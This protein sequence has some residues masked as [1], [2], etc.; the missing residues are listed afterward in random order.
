L[1][2]ERGLDLGTIEGSGPGGAVLAADLDRAPAAPTKR[3]RFDPAA[4]RHAIG[5]AMARSKRE[6]PH[7]YLSRPIDLEAA[8]GW[9]EATNAAL[10]VAERMLPAVLLLKASALALKEHAAFNGHYID[11][12]FEPAAAVNVGWAIALRGGGLIAP[13]IK[14]ADTLSP[15]AL[16]TAMRDLVKRA[17]SGGLRSSELSATTV[18]ITSLGDRG[19]QTVWPVIHPPQVAMLGFGAI[20]VRP[21]VVD[22]RLAARR[23]V[24]VSLAA[25]H[26]VSDGHA[27]SALLA[28]IDALLATPETL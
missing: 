6:I 12:R 23:A 24:T 1:A 15:P 8:L 17:R 18:T 10:G 2:R 13:A 21:L 5:V 22:G 26:R 4:M 9:L 16:M 20:D 28:A 14:S 3:P 19:A 11:E 27:G 7:Y 25:D